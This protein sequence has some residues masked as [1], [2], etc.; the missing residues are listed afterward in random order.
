MNICKEKLQLSSPRLFLALEAAEQ[1]QPKSLLKT[2]SL[3][4]LSELDSLRGSD[5]FQKQL[6]KE[7]MKLEGWYQILSDINCQQIR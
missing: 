6:Q 1:E 5:R 2:R 4:L 3:H 7:D